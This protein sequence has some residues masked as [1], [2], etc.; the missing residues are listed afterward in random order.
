MNTQTDVRPAEAAV[1]PPNQ[2]RLL[3]VTAPDYPTH[4]STYGPLPSSTGPHLLEQVQLS[5]LTGR[6][7]AGFPTAVKLRAVAAAPGRAVVV[8][9]AAE[10]EPASTKDRQLLLTAPH[11]VLD[12]VQVAAR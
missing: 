11:V 2:G 6:G 3:A 12:G 5:G 8:A 4:L 1:G 10:G 7:G 9:N